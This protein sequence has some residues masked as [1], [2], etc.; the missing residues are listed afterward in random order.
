MYD[1]GFERHPPGHPVAAGD[2]CSLAQDL[3][4][5]G[6]HV[7]RPGHIAEDLAVAYC[8]RSGIGAAKPDRRFDYCV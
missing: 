1:P 8:D 4:K 7:Q 3:P 2:N 5:L 6:F